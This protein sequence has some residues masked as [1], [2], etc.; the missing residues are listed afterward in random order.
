M[1]TEQLNDCKHL[2][3][4]QINPTTLLLACGVCGIR[5]FET[6]NGDF[7]DILLTDT[8]ILK[9]QLSPQQ[10]DYYLSI[11]SSHG[12]EYCRAL[13]VYYNLTT[14]QYFYLHPE[15]VHDGKVTTCKQCFQK[16]ATE[17]PAFSV[18][19][20][21]YGDYRR[22]FKDMEL[23]PVEL[24]TIALVRMFCLVIKVSIYIYLVLI[25]T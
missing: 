18:A 14:D 11:A 12:F 16:L 20:I 6:A 24:A 13:S 8:K 22:V 5:D 2:F 15:L 3:N 7:Y 9:L 4:H 19:K 23:T 10:K 21:D 1:S 17:V 25:V